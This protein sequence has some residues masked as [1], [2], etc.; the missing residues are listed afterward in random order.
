MERLKK[1]TYVHN[2]IIYDEG[3]PSCGGI[4]AQP[5]LTNRAVPSKELIQILALDVVIEVFDEENAV[6]S[7]WELS[8]C[9]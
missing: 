8:C 6:R 5:Y 4:I 9:R 7:R 2:V 3:R 1:G